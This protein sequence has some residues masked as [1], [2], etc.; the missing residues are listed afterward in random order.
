L[1]LINDILDIARY[2]AGRG[3][4]QEEVFDPAEKITDTIAMMSG[5]AAKAKV[6]LMGDIASDLPCLKGDK[7]RMRQILLNLVSNALKFTPSGGK[8]M[9]RAFR[10]DQG[11]VLRVTDTGI[12]MAHSDFHKALEPFG[13]VDSSLA[14][15]YDGI[16]LGLPLTRQMVELHGGTL[17]LDSVVG[18]GT[19]VTITLPAWRLVSRA[20]AAA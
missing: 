20:E 15:K 12:G 9:V 19:T 16:G 14:R 13:Q 17:E 18:Q 7:R 11:F 2:D 6:T 10:T 8:V 4:L 3:E 5:Q 1:S